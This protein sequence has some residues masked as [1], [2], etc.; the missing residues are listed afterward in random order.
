LPATFFTPRE[1]AAI[2]R[3]SIKAF[4]RLTD[5]RTGDPT[6]PVTRLPGGGLLIPRLAFEAWLRDRTQGMRGPLRLAVVA[7]T[8]TPSQRTDGAVALKGEAQGG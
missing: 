4:Y 2:L 5:E 1:A 8:S 6:F 3:R 7:P